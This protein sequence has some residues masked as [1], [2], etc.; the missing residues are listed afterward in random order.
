[1][2]FNH[3]ASNGVNSLFIICLKSAKVMSKQCLGATLTSL[4]CGMKLFKVIHL[5]LI[6][7]LICLL[8]LS[9]Q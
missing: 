8:N 6:D 4:F 9:F 3:S 7:Y 5:L 2:S 1:M